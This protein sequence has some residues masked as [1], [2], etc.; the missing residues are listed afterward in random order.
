M[1][2][3]TVPVRVVLA[4]VRVAW[5]A[6]AAVPAAKAVTGRIPP[7]AT[8]KATRRARRLFIIFYA[9]TKVLTRMS[10]R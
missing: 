3:P 5:V 8:V 6:G 7:A 4:M 2:V 1:G 10:S 9:K